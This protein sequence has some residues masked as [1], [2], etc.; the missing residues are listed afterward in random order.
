MILLHT[1][2]TIHSVFNVAQIHA[3]R[4]RYA[5]TK[6]ASRFPLSAQTVLALTDEELPVFELYFARS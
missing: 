2:E 1:K 6:L 5:M 4:L 3:S